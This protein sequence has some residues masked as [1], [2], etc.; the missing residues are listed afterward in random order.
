M[1][2]IGN[3]RTGLMRRLARTRNEHQ[4][5]AE[6]GSVARVRGFAAALAR[7]WRMVAPPGSSIAR[8]QRASIALVGGVVIAML[9]GLAAVAVELGRGYL[10]QMAEQRTADSAAYA[11]ALAYNATGSAI[12]MSSAVTNL[13]VL[14]GLSSTAASATLVTSPSGDGNS[15]VRVNVTTSMP[16]Y[17]AGIFKGG[18]TM[19][20]TATSYAEVRPN[21]SACII[22]LLAGGTGVTLSG[23]T[24]VTTASC[25]VASDATVSVPCGTTMTTKTLDYNF[26]AIPSQP[27]GGIKPPSGTASVNIVKAVT[28]DP[29]AGSAGIAAAF[30]HLSS[31]ASLAGPSGPSVPAGTSVDFDYGG[32][33]ADPVRT[34]LGTIGCTGALARSTWTVTCPAGGTYKFGTITIHGGLT[35]NFAVGGSASNTYDFSGRVD[36]GGSGANFGPGTFNIAGGIITGG[37]STTTFSAGTYA[38]GP[39]TVSCAGA[40]YSICNTGTSLSFGAGSFNIAGGINDGGGE[41]LSLG[42]GSSA[43][44]FSIGPSSNGYAINIGGGGVATF[45]DMA[46][47]TFKAVGNIVTGGSSILTFGIAPAHDLN[48]AISLAGS[49]TFGAG[50]YTVAGAVA[51]GG[52]GGGGT[53]NG[54]GVSMIT[55]GSFS[56]A[57][58]YAN[59]TLTAPTSGTMA[60]VVVASNGSGGASFSE[61][62]SSNTLSGAFYFPNSPITLSGA[63]NVGSGAG[64]CL[65]LIGSAITLAGGSALASMCSSL[66]GSVTGG[67][68]VLV[69]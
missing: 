34:Q 1:L 36:I 6:L 24:A 32:N 54:G 16:L 46:S 61:G 3:A 63:G 51:L 40:N 48:G 41:Q 25:A 30:S 9:T 11:G 58:G 49:A 52:A 18:R 67:T 60:G 27:C 14:N 45:G 31:V 44:N 57:A 15:A 19:P 47:G 39:G 69:Q 50:I 64:Q 68:V 23:G 53:V 13:A 17:L 26:A 62:A 10:T 7:R 65:E 4:S 42:G 37:G 35:L 56:V 55:S 8:D 29:L 20:V 12:K 59:M 28:T 66:G 43:N 38:I 33:L 21:A 5:A 2:R 22:A